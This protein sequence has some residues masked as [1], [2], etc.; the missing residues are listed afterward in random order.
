MGQ[1]EIARRT[2]DREWEEEREKVSSVWRDW[3]VVTYLLKVCPDFPGV[4]FTCYFGKEIF[5]YDCDVV[6]FAQC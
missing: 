3:G 5:I 2:G 4:E 6:R 1:V